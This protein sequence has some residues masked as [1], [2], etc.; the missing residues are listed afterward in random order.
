MERIAIETEED[1]QKLISK[2]KE[3]DVEIL[4]TDVS[5]NPD[6]HNIR[7][8]DKGDLPSAPPM[9]PRDFTA[10]VGDTFYMPSENYGSNIDVGRVFRHMVGGNTSIDNVDRTKILAKYI[11]DI[12]RPGR[13]IS[14]SMALVKQKL[15]RIKDPDNYVTGWLM[16]LDHDELFKLIYASETQTIGSTNKFPDNKKFYQ[17]QTIRDWM[18]KNNVPVVY[19]QYINTAMMIRLGKDLYFN[20]INVLNKLNEVKFKE[21]YKKLFP[22]YRIHTLDIP[23][24]GDGSLCAVKPGLCVALKS[25]ENYKETFPD[26]EIVSLEGE[27]W[28]KVNGF[29]KMKEKNKGRWFVEGEENNDDLINF[30]DDWLDHWVTYVEETVFDVNMLVV[31]ENNV[32]CNGYNEKVF[33]AFDRHGVTPHIVNMRH[34]YFWDGGLHCVTSDLHREGERKDYFPDRNYVS[35]LIA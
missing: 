7:I 11:D 33:N 28:S 1:Y 27:S 13:P 4:R 26:W 18:N 32:I 14:P 12:M 23:G 8:L 29:L 3:F 35:D 17:F 5:E 22:D 16:G 6:D 19:D 9:C 15:K 34:R 2:L 25:E 24:H 31:D 30:V 20:H 21:K 10:M